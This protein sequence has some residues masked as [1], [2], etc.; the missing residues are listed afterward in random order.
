[1]KLLGS[2]PGFFI[3][4]VIAADLKDE[5]T[6]PEVREECMMT[7]IMEAREGRQAFTRAV[8]RGSI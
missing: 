1:M 5:G 4:G 8:G 2:E 6:R 3:V 7:V